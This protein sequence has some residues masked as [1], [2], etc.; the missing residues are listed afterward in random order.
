M[1]RTRP[2]LRHGRM[3]GQAAV[4]VSQRGH[5]DEYHLA[6]WAR[7]CLAARSSADCGSFPVASRLPLA[8]MQCAPRVCYSVHHPSWRSAVDPSSVCM[9]I[10]HVLGL[11][12]DT[13][14]LGAQAIRPL[15]C[16]RPPLQ[17]PCHCSAPWLHRNCLC[18]QD[19]QIA[20]PALRLG[21]RHRSS[22]HICRDAN[23]GTQRASQTWRLTC[24]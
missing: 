3:C 4:S 7:G 18:I 14:S 22:G 17:H 21:T 23:P 1:N 20:G 8:A 16:P 9:G 19:H 11:F 13:L 24:R 5:A 15:Q 10:R 6:G 2:P 12:D